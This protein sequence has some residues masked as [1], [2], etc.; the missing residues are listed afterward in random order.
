MSRG[1]GGGGLGA[2]LG[3]GGELGSSHSV[4]GGG[5][6]GG[7]TVEDKMRPDIWRMLI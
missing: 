5:S 1:G 4:G 3:R 7:R 2:L 6:E